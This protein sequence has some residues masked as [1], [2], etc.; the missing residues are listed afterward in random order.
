MLSDTKDVYTPAKPLVLSTSR[1][2]ILEMGGAS[3]TGMVSDMTDE[4]KTVALPRLPLSVETTSMASD[5]L[6]VA[7]VTCSE[8][9]TL[10]ISSGTEAN[11]VASES[12]DETVAV[13][14]T[15]AELVDLSMESVGIVSGSSSKGVRRTLASLKVS[16]EPGTAVGN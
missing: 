3:A 8:E 2:A 14:P 13:V 11:E 16:E 5:T 6:F 9:V 15:K 4:G 1:E 10:S 7:E 12:A